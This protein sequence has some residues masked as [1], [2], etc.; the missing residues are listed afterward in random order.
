MPMARRLASAYSCIGPPGPPPRPIAAPNVYR[1]PPAEPPRLE[2]AQPLA[3]EPPREVH[4]HIHG[5]TPEDLAAILRQI[6]GG[7]MPPV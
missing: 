3:I 5:A 2:A 6:S 1:P 7:R 4:N